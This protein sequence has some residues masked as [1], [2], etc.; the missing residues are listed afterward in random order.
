MHSTLLVADVTRGRPRLDLVV[1]LALALAAALGSLVTLHRFGSLDRFGPL[2][3][4][5]VTASA[6]G[7][8][9][10]PPVK[11]VEFIDIA[12]EDARAVNARRPFAP[13][14]LTAA[15]ALVDRRS[16]L[17]RARATDCLAAA[18]WYEAGDDPAGERSV[19]QTV[20]NRA[21]H[22]AF[23][24]QICG[25]VFQGA[26]RTTGCQ[27]TFACDGA[28]R[29]TPSSVAWTRARALAKQALAGA[30]DSDVGLATHYHTDWVMPVWSPK[31][32]KIAKVRTHLFFRWPGAWGGKAAFRRSL[33]AGEPLIPALGRLSASHYRLAS[34]RSVPSEE[35][36][37]AADAMAPV[38]F[39]DQRVT[40]GSS[41]PDDVF[42]VALE[43]GRAAGSHAV[44]AVNLCGKRPRCLVLGW[45]GHGLVSKQL[46]LPEA[47]LAGLSFVYRR[48]APGEDAAY[49]DCATMPRE[50]ETQCLPRR[51]IEV[52]VLVNRP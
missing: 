14:P 13:T 24:R 34:D 29:R 41:A 12:P 25:V 16:E 33:A 42:F 52:R 9:A 5:R 8:A 30:V 18:A 27:F 11:P 10:P 51:V 38:R 20:L 3:E 21:R 23:P 39:V 19:I 31:L 26:E 22:P 45:L 32:E 6:P 43:A 4:A 36:A 28:L 2:G 15:P 40:T 17:D 47:A 44:S 37:P 49:W 7:T 48:T 46:P 35:A 50:V 1:G